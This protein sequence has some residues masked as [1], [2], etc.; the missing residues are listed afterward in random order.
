MKGPCWIHSEEFPD[1]Q[2]IVVL[3]SPPL[4][5]SFRRR[6]RDIQ[7]RNLDHC[8]GILASIATHVEASEEEDPTLKSREAEE[9]RRLPSDE[10][11]DDVD[12]SDV[13]DGDIIMC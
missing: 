4:S 8:A 5:L 11:D 12:T 13:A 9:R 2:L 1:Q 6:T 7:V 3:V 10:C